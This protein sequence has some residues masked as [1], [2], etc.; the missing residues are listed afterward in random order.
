[1]GSNPTRSI[2]FNLVKYGIK[3]RLF[4]VVARQK[5]GEDAMPYHVVCRHFCLLF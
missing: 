2:S 3:L 4:W 5:L 1:V